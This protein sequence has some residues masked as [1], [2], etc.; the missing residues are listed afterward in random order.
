[1]YREASQRWWCRPGNHW[2]RLPPICRGREPDIGAA[3]IVKA[4]NLE[5][6]DNCGT[7]GI[8]IRLNLGLVLAG[9]IRVGV[10][11]Q[12]R[13]R[14]ICEGQKS[15]REDEEQRE[16]ERDDDPDRPPVAREK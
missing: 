12:P 13:E 9:A 16:R 6:R 14:Y 10:G 3:A 8:G 4:A 1:M 2:S 5:G 7:K 11:T 15:G